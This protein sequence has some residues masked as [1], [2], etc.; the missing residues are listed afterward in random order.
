MKRKI[1]VLAVAMFG[2][3]VTGFAQFDGMEPKGTLVSVE[4][5]TIGF[6]MKTE[7]Y[8]D[9]EEDKFVHYL[10]VAFDGDMSSIF[11]TEYPISA[12]KKLNNASNYLTIDLKEDTELTQ[13]KYGK[14]EQSEEIIKGHREFI[15]D[16]ADACKKVASAIQG[17]LTALES[18]Y[19][20]PTSEMEHSFVYGQKESLQMVEWNGTPFRTKSYDKYKWEF[21]AF[22]NDAERS[23]ELYKASYEIG[24]PEIIGV[25]FS[26]TSYDDVI[27][28]GTTGK[29][30]YVE[31]PENFGFMMT[32]YKESSKT[33]EYTTLYFEF[34][35]EAEAEE[36]R[37]NFQ[38][39]LDAYKANK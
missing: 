36:C 23:F 19:Y 14:D 12:I 1:V 22:A 31:G 5:K 13:K 7:N 32:F 29:T 2:Y 20:V 26:S 28:I 33:S 9:V 34:E 8:I 11:V 15:F 21:Y 18:T 30:C 6:V 4:E 25:E 17:K 10:V 3:V 24:K 38:A 39:V 27:K 16:K 37:Q 35:T